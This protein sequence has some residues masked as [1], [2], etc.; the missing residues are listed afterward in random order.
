MK[1]IIIILLCLIPWFACSQILRLCQ[2][3]EAE[4]PDLPQHTISGGIY[5]GE[6]AAIV[7]KALISL[8][9]Q[10][11]I[12]R[13]PW[14]RCKAQ[15]EIGVYDGAIGMGWND[16]RSAKYV[17]PE[18]GNG[19]PNAYF[20]I[21]NVNYPIYV[22]ASSELG[23]D[24]TQFSHVRLGITAPKGYLVEHKLK[25][26]NVLLKTDVGVSSWLSL[27]KNKRVDGVVIV[28]SI[29][30]SMV[31]ED[32]QNDIRKL[33]TLFYQQPVF[34]VF[35]LKQ[36][37]LSSEQMRDVWQSIANVRNTVAPLD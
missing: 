20:R 17:F 36:Q 34:L 24:G 8:Q 29:G 15:V 37:K 10:F 4:D 22:H 2:E 11:T 3:S 27:L 19:A 26:L 5:Y 35:S 21:R 6:Y 12:D 18:A 13:L 9:Y 28:E 30:D 33:D 7:A 32:G 14:R 25:E 23:W 1:T 16:E 31:R